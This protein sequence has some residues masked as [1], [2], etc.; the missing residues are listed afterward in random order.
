VRPDC[1]GHAPGFGSY[2]L[3]QVARKEPGLSDVFAYHDALVAAQQAGDGSE[4]EVIVARLRREYEH[5]CESDAWA[6]LR[7]DGSRIPI[8]M[9]VFVAGGSVRWIG[10]TDA[11]EYWWEAPRSIESRWCDA[12]RSYL[13]FLETHPP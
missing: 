3:I 4:F 13:E 9:P 1:D 5:L 11:R 2:Q 12:A 6:I 10:A 8:V 7:P